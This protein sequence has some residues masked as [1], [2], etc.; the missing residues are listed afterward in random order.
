MYCSLNSSKGGYIRVET[1]AH[2]RFYMS[3]T[4]IDVGEDCKLR[5][6]GVFSSGF[7][8]QSLGFGPSSF[9]ALACQLRTNDGFGV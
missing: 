5:L 2:I 3:Y 9:G 6:K 4:L 1:T 7:G 8:T